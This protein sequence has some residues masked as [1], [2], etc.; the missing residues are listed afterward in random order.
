MA[1]DAGKGFHAVT[2]EDSDEVSNRQRKVQVAIAPLQKF[3]RQIKNDMGLSG[4]QV[5]VGL[6]SDTEIARLNE[7]FRKMKGPTDVLSFP[8]R[9]GRKPMRLRAGKAAVPRGTMLGDIAISPETARRYVK[10]QGRAL[11]I[12][13]RILILHGV[14][15]LLGYDHETDRGAMSRLEKSLRGRYGLPQ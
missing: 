11:N 7:S 14:L 4:S 10:K 1:K 8:A 2:T 6:V 13:L 3:L 12:E 15:H 5:T 9:A